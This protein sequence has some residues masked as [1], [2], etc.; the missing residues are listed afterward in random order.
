MH[1]CSRAYFARCAGYLLLPGHREELAGA[2][3]RAI[4]A[5]SGRRED[6]AL[7]AVSRQAHA[8]LQVG[9]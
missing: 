1:V 5:H 6:S 7:E 8:A 2:L 4:L 3:N 9:A